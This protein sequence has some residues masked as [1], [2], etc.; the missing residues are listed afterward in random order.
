MFA[1]FSPDSDWS[2]H[3]HRGWT[4]LISFALQA[5]AVGC[6][7]L[8]P[9]L[10]TEGLP[11]LVLLAPFL[12]PAPPSSAPPEPPRHNLPSTGQSNL[13]GTR[14]VA[15]PEIPRDVIMLTETVA[16][17]P[18]I[19]PGAVGVRHGFGD[20]RGRG[21]VFDSVPGSG[22]MLL[23]PP[24]PVVHH[25]RVSHMM[26]GNLIYRVQPNYSVLARQARIQDQVV[27]RAIISREGAIENLQ[28]LSGHP[29]LAPAAVDA[30]RQWRYRPYVLNG[31][32]VEVE[33]Q[34][35]VNFVLGGG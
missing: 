17:P 28:V 34:V 26:E 13:M 11:K 5:L 7:L 19:D 30:V 3:S 23:P 32:R 16:P 12:A 24:P 27:L 15:P 1:D 10:Y 2:S 4:T 14:L 9:L 6:L 20:A 8:L 25:P 21:I 29:M 18:M 31:E 33:T 35:T 22:Q